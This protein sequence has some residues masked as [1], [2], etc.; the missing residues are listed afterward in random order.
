MSN[1]I[2]LNNNHFIFSSSNQPPHSCSTTSVSI[3]QD[4]Q[5]ASR[6]EPNSWKCGQCSK[7]FSQRLLLQ[8][9]ICCKSPEKPYQCGHCSDS[10]SQPSELRSHVI[11]HSNDRPFKCGFCG[12]SFAGAT[13]LNNHMRT[14]TG[15]RPFLCNNCGR[16]FSIATQLSRHMRTPGECPMAGSL[17]EVHN[18]VVPPFTS[19]LTRG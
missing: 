5:L 18:D 17:S 7:T 8:M 14:H 16:T 19:T 9:H 6:D 4:D 2:D 12:R 10:F 15:E 13:T 11:T 1:Q 3:F